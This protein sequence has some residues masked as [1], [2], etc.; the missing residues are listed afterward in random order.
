MG[1]EMRRR[2]E[3]ITNRALVIRDGHECYVL[4]T[5]LTDAER[6]E[7]AERQRSPEA[8]KRFGYKLRA[9]RRAEDKPLKD[10]LK[11]ALKDARN[12]R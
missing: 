4:L 1:G 10:A 6:E 11:A 3:V 8:R 5:H 9:A 2:N 7:F 12:E